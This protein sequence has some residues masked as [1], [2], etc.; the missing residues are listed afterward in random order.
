MTSTRTTTARERHDMGN[1][2]RGVPTGWC[3]L[4]IDRTHRHTTRHN[5]LKH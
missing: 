4:R 5:V 1:L 3:F 2:G